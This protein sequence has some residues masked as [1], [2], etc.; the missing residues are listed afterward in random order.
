[1]NWKFQKIISTAIVLGMGCIFIL[2]GLGHTEWQFEFCHFSTKKHRKFRIGCESG[3][4]PV[5]LR[6]VGLNNS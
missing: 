6:S 2:K 1:M 3:F 4:Y 5:T